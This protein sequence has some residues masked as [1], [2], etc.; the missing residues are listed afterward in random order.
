MTCYRLIKLSIII[1]I[2]VGSLCGSDLSG[3]S[4]GLLWI[5]IEWHSNCKWLIDLNTFLCLSVCLFHKYIHT[6]IHTYTH[7]HIHTYTHTHIHAYTHT[8]IHAYT[9]TRIH[10][11]THTRIHAYTHTRIHTYTHTHARTHARTHTYIHMVEIDTV[12][13][14]QSRF[15]FGGWYCIESV[16]SRK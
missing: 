8:R 14:S 1:I 16:A 4:T 5:A 10:A 6:Y 15:G 13:Q 2:I 9:H 7:T 12:W 11:Y 3:L